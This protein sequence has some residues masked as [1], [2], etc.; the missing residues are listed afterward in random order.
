M[1]VGIIGSGSVAQALGRGFAKRG[2]DVKLGS[3]SPEK[4]AEWVQEVGGSASAGTMAEAAG[5]G[6]MLVL[7]CMGTETESAIETAGASNFEGKVLIDPT[8]PLIHGDGIPRLAYGPTDSGGEVVQRTLPKTKVVKSFGIVN[9]GQM[10]DPDTSG[11]PPTMFV[12]GEDAGAKETV[13]GVLHDFGWEDVV[14]LGG[15][16]ASREMESL[17]VL[18][19]R[20]AIPNQ[21][22]QA[23]FKLL[24]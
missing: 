21:A 1:K 14:D 20:F 18:W 6:E 17:C 15:I 12:A 7:A 19:C 13:A 3:R 9:S 10:V 5:H 22:W 16:E 11:G 24:R 2:D 4:L 8:N 23:T